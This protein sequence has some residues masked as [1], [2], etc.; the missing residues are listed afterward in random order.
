MASILLYIELR[1]SIT[2]IACIKKI[3]SNTAII[4]L[5]ASLILTKIYDLGG[6][7]AV[8][9][10]RLMTSRLSSMSCFLNTYGISFLGRQ[11]IRVGTLEA[12]NSGTQAYILDNFYMNLLV[13]YGL[14]FTRV[15]FV[16]Y[17]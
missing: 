9:F 1:F 3:I 5:Y 2:Q 13:S 6:A 16:L 4:S 10:N 7:I 14:L 15:F 8:E 11:T 17:I 12:L